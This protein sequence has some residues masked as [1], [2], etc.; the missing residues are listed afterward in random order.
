MGTIGYTGG[1]WTNSETLSKTFTGYEAYFLNCYQSSDRV[2]VTSNNDTIASRAVWA[3]T[4]WFV[5]NCNGLDTTI[6]AIRNVSSNDNLWYIHGIKL[7]K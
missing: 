5:L 3:C 4:L 2:Y 6:N 7:V 1:S